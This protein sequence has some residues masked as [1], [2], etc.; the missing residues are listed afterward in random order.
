MTHGLNSGLLLMIGFT[1]TPLRRPKAQA[2]R[3]LP[4]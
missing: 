4:V 1:L 3:N 2:I